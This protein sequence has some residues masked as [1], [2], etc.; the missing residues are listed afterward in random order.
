MKAGQRGMAITGLLVGG[1]ALLVGGMVLTVVKG[2]QIIGMGVQVF[3]AWF[4]YVPI[5]GE[6][7]PKPIPA[8]DFFWPALALVGGLAAFFLGWVVI[9]RSAALAWPTRFDRSLRK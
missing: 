3:G 2:S 4:S 7:S 5:F 8:Y 1:A 9:I 6:A